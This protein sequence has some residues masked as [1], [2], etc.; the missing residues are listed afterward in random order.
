LRYAIT[1]AI[2]A[3]SEFIRTRNA[4]PVGMM[5]PPPL[6]P[7]IAAV[8][9]APREALHSVA[10]ARF[11][12][13]QLSATQVGLRPRDLDRSGRRDLM[14]LMRRLE[15]SPA[16]LDFLIPPG[17]YADP[18]H[19]DRA[20][21]AVLAA[22]DLA[23]DLGRVAVTIELPAAMAQSDS[24]AGHAEVLGAILSHAEKTGVIV[25]NL[26]DAAM[27]VDG[28]A[29]AMDI[30]SLVMKGVSP[31]AALAR[32]RHVLASVR[33]SGATETGARVPFGRDSRIDPLELQV[34]LSIA[35]YRNAVV[36][37]A[38]GW[39]DAMVGLNESAAAWSRAAPFRIE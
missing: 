33:C 12:Q 32:V 18:V 19:A 6:A 21:G 34:A 17:H 11:Q 8:P 35:G 3:S 5:E 29:S 15:L 26:G 36:L 16:G 25:A 31:A 7:T 22:V 13:V 4:Y 23:A 37:D 28:L 30:V 10:E 2:D 9:L 24:A 27:N 1:V 39:P 38:R 14:A 20:V